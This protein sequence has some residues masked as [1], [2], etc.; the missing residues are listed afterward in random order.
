MSLGVM[1]P[2]AT[3][4]TDIVVMAYVTLD[5]TARVRKRE[6]RSGTGAFPFE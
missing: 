3:V 4:Q 6:R 1:Y 5:Q 2:M